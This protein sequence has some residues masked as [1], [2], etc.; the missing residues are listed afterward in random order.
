M[1]GMFI[2]SFTASGLFVSDACDYVLSKLLTFSTLLW[3]FPLQ[4]GKNL[5]VD[6]Q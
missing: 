4:S 1:P 3:F 5:N 6:L 2:R